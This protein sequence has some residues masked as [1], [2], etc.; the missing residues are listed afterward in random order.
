MNND[1]K[2]TFTIV[3]LLVIFIVQYFLM[4]TKSLEGYI[5]NYK[6]DEEH[7]QF[8]YVM[9]E[10]IAKIVKNK[11][12]HSARFTFVSNYEDNVYNLNGMDFSILRYELFP[13]DVVLRSRYNYPIKSVD[14]KDKLIE[15]Y[16]LDYILVANKNV[17]LYD[18]ITSNSLTLYKVIDKKKAKLE[19]VFEDELSLYGLYNLYYRENETAYFFDK[20]EV[21][22]KQLEL[23]D[24]YT[25]FVII[26]DFICDLFE[27]NED[28]LALEYANYYLSKINP[29]DNLITVHVGDY[30]FKEKDYANAKKYYS[31]C[32]SSPL[33]DSDYVNERLNDDA[34][35]G[36]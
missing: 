26:N 1:N 32:L 33:C 4:M 22:K 18:Y 14:D 9:Q 10:M 30:Y 31:D 8:S 7:I 24:D 19:V 23:H 17:Q 16:D 35:K 5:L 28:K 21:L 34:M 6:Y 25:S 11:I 29:I 3:C 15:K 13:I 2:V 36:V 20:I 27:N 12:D